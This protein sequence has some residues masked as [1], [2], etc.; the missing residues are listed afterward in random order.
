VVLGV[1]AAMNESA[2]AME[3]SATRAQSGRFV[4]FANTTC[5]TMGL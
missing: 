5:R 4:C 2:A 3:V 1:E